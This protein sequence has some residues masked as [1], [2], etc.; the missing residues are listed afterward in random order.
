M[1]SEGSFKKK[2][3]KPYQNWNPTKFNCSVHMS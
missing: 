3:K 1:I 2:K